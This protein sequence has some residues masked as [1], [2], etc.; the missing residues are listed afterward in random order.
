MPAQTLTV[1]I[2]TDAFPTESDWPRLLNLLQEAKG[3]GGELAVLPELPLNPWSPATQV[4]LE[5]DA[6]EDGGPRQR[7]FAKA[8]SAIGIALLGGA[9][10]RDPGSGIRHNTGLLYGA[11]GSCLARYR[12][13]HLPE[14]EGY[15]ETSHYEAGE[16][17]PE[18]VRGL[19]LS[20]GMQLCSDV[21][22]TTGFHL[23][24]AQGVEVV[25]APR[26]TPPQT[27]ERWRLVLR[28][29]AVTSCAYVVSTNRPSPTPDG[30]IGGPSI[31]IGPSAEVLV[32]TTDRLALVT[33]DREVVRAAKA[34]YP[35]YLKHYPELYAKGWMGVMERSR[36]GSPPH[37]S[38]PMA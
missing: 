32:E 12:K 36:L 17:P 11:D 25:L 9:I 37:R 34:N 28:A 38:R 13:V 2:L 15:W 20:V 30:L 35:G 14:E 22:R 31:A 24:A 29:N 18:V 4:P 1:A 26:C 3:R 16:D 6:E 5:E 7:L 8:A 27:Y 21:N 10:I 19:T 33:L 23:L